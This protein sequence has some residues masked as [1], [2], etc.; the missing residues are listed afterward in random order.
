MKYQGKCTC[1]AVQ[2]GILTE[3]IMKYNCHCSHCRRFASRYEDEKEPAAYY[4]S[5]FV[6]RWSV[7]VEGDVEFEQ[8]TGVGAAR[9]FGLQRG[10][11]ASCKQPV[12]E[13]GTRLALLYAM[14]AIPPL[15]G[16]EPDTNI[17][18]DSGLKQ[19]TLGLKTT[20]YSDLG[21]LLY[22]V[23]LVLMVSIRMLPTSIFALFF[24]SHK[25]KEE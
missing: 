5:A 14:V 12:W 10:R 20:I 18:Y 9:L 17:Y 24:G 15:Q 13:K 4:T 16:L 25:F 3:P 2:V 22:E 7:R 11:C 6:W 1:G 23:G 8:S 21:S 19:G